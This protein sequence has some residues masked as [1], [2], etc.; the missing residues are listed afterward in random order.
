[1]EMAVR[2]VFFNYALPLDCHR[3]AVCPGMTHLTSLCLGWYNRY[4]ERLLKKSY[5]KGSGIL[6][7]P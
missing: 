5:L 4:V 6:K 2:P 1:M 3:I 7:Y